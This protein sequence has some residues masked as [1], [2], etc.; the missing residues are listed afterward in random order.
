MAETALECVLHYNCPEW[1]DSIRAARLEAGFSFDL[2]DEA[3]WA[4]LISG[5]HTRVMEI[6][7]RE[8]RNLNVEEFSEYYLCCFYSDYE[9]LDR[10]FDFEV[11]KGPPWVELECPAKRFG[12]D[13]QWSIQNARKDIDRN[14]GSQEG[15]AKGKT[16][17]EFLQWYFS[18][19]GAKEIA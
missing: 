7:E 14:L 15:L 10:T 8:T 1:N 17:N 19:G 5:G 3:L 6:A 12:K 11:I 18:G 2:P 9:R 16:Y 13:W 4:W